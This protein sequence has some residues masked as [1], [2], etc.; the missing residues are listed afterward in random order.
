MAQVTITIP[1]GQL[2]R[3]VDAMCDVYGYTD[4]DGPKPAFAQAKL[5]E[6]VRNI[7]RSV[8]Q[9]RQERE[10]L[11]AITPPTDVDVT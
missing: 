11:D 9:A 3:V 7:V 8:E 5:V 1:N 10:A 4:G 2:T 6:H